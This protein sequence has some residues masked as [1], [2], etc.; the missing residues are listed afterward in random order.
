MAPREGNPQVTDGPVIMMTS[1]NGNIFRV[2]GPLYGKFTG[3]SPHKGQWRRAL[4]PSLICAW[5][6]GWANNR[7][8]GDSRRHRAHYCN[9][10]M[11]FQ[12]M[13][14]HYS[15]ESNI[16]LWDYSMNQSISDMFS[17]SPIKIVPFHK[18]FPLAVNSPN[19]MNQPIRYNN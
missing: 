9:G 5:S 4:M 8:S 7:N 15:P 14:L 19:N 6:N 11:C 12:I 3:H 17:N 1:S 18:D 13:S 16:Y 10:R 2:T